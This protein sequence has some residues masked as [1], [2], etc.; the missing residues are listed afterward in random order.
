VRCRITGLIRNAG[1]APCISFDRY[2]GCSIWVNEKHRLWMSRKPQTGG[3]Q[4]NAGTGEW[5]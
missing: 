1:T 3:K 4:I 5:E 2:V